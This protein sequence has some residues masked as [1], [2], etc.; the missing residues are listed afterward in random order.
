VGITIASKLILVELDVVF[1]NSKDNIF[2]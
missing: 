1:Y 2:L